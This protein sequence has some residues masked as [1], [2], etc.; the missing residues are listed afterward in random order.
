M[1][2]PTDKHLKPIQTLEADLKQ[3][4]WV[5]TPGKVFTAE[6]KDHHIFQYDPRINYSLHFGHEVIFYKIQPPAIIT[7]PN[8]P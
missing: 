6:D 1:S 4:D 2:D 7:L 3:G 5:Y 8:Q